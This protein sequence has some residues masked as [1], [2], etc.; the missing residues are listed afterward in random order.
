MIYL[1][2]FGYPT[3]GKGILLYQK[4]SVMLGSS[5]VAQEVENPALYKEVMDAVVAAKGNKDLLAKSFVIGQDQSGNAALLAIKVKQP[6]GTTK[7]IDISRLL[8]Q[9]EGDAAQ[10]HMSAEYFESQVDRVQAAL[11]KSGTVGEDFQFTE[12]QRISVFSRVYNGSPPSSLFSGLESGDPIKVLEF[13]TANRGGNGNNGHY[14]RSIEE[15]VK[16]LGDSVIPA[17]KG[18]ANGF[19]Y[20]DQDGNEVFIGSEKVAK[21]PNGQPGAGDE[22]ALVAYKVVENP[23]GT[24]SQVNIDLKISGSRGMNQASDFVDPNVALHNA[25]FDGNPT[26]I[27]KA[28]SL[29]PQNTTP[30]SVISALG[31]FSPEVGQIQDINIGSDLKPIWVKGYV[32]VDEN[33]NTIVIASGKGTDG[34]AGI[35]AY[36][37]AA[38]SADNPNPEP[39]L[40]DVVSKQ[41][42]IKQL[43]ISDSGE[44][45]GPKY[46]STSD[47]SSLVG[48]GGYVFTSEQY[49]LID[50]VQWVVGTNNTVSRYLE[51]GVIET[52]ILKD[53]GSLGQGILQDGN[54]E[55]V[56]MLAPSDKVGLTDAGWQINDG[57]GNRYTLQGEPI[58]ALEPNQIISSQISSETNLGLSVAQ[59]DQLSRYLANFGSDVQIGQLPN[60]EVLVANDAGEVLGV[61]KKEADGSVRF[62]DNDKNGTEINQDGKSQQVVSGLNEAELDRQQAHQVQAGFGAVQSALSLIQALENGNTFAASV[63]GVSMINQMFAAS[64]S[65][66]PELASF[67]ETLG[68]VGAGLG[69]ISSA[70]NLADALKSG[71]ALA[72]LQS[73]ATLGAQGINLYASMEGLKL[74][75][76]AGNSTGTL[77]TVAQDLGV[78]GAGVGLV[79][80][81]QSGNP[82]SMV[83]SSLSLL[84]ALG[85]I[86]PYGAVAAVIISLVSSMFGSDQPMLEGQAQA[87]WDAAGNTHVITTQDNEG[88]GATAT[89]WMNTLVSGLQ[90]Q[91]AGMVD[92]NGQPLYGLITP[93]LPSVGYQ[94]DPDGFNLANGAK[95]HLYLKWVDEN[96]QEQTRYYDGAGSRGDGT[97][98]T[99]VS[100]FMK[101]AMEAVVPAWEA[102]TV[103]Q[104]YLQDGVSATAKQG[105]RAG[106]PVEDAQHLTQSFTALSF[107]AVAVP[108]AAANAPV[109]VDIDGDGYLEKTDWISANQGMLAIDLNGDGKIGAGELLNLDPGSTLERNSLRW[110]DANRDGLLDARDP[111]FAALKVWIDANHD[112]LSQTATATSAGELQSMAAAGIVAINFASNPPVLV[113]ADGST[114]AL[115]VQQLTGDV[116]GVAYM[117][118][119]GGLLE[120]QEGGETILHAINTREFDGQAAHTH[121]GDADADGG[122]VLVGAGNADLKSTTSKTLPGNSQRTDTTLN[123]GDARLANGAAGAAISGQGAAQSAANTTASQVRSNPLAFVPNGATT[124]AQQVRQVTEEM[125]RNADNSLFGLSSVSTPL[126]AVGVAAAA[127][128]WPAVAAASDLTPVAQ[129]IGSVAPASTAAGSAMSST[130]LGALLAG[131]TA[132]GSS[133]GAAGELLVD[134]VSGPVTASTRTASVIATLLPNPVPVASAPETLVM[135]PGAGATGAEG[136]VAAGGNSNDSTGA[137][138]QTVGTTAASTAASALSAPAAPADVVLDYP[139]VV[140]EHVEGIEDIVLR[141]PESLL[142]ANDSTINFPAF[143]DRQM[144][145][146]SSVFSATH[147]QVALRTNEEGK[148]E[149]VFLPEAN[150]HGLASFNYTVTDQYG[151][152]SVG[153]TTVSIAAVNDAPVVRDDR[154]AGDE[155]TVLMF[156]AADLLANDSDVDSAVD[157]DVLRI[158]R[159]GQA[160]HGQV[161]LDPDGIIRFI[162]DLNYNGPAQFTYWVGDRDVSQLV[163][164]GGEGYEIPGTMHL[165]VIPVNDLPVVTG[166]QVDSDEDIVLDFAQSFL[167]ANDTDVDIATNGQVL[168]ITAVSNAQHGVVELLQD[169][170]VRFTPELNYFGPAAF[171][172]TVDDGNGGRVV[173]TTVVNLAPVNDAP[174]VVGETI[175]FD[176]DIVQTID[177]ALLLANDSD[178][179]NAHSELSIIAVDNAT[180][181]VVSLNPDG[182]IRFVP[183]AD[184]F[185]AASF[186]YTV[187]DGV[188]GFTVGTASLQ[189]NPVNDAPRLQGETATTDE[190]QVL[191][192]SVDGLLSNDHDVDNDHAELRLT[193]VG[194]ASHGTVR[195]ENG[196]IIFTPD[197][198]YFGAASFT[199]VVDDGVGGQSEA[200]VDLQFNSVNDVPVVND[201][202]LTGKR[203]VTYTLT[204]A[205]LL[206]N[207]TDVEDPNALSIVAVRNASHGSVVLNPNG[208]ITFVPESG[209]AGTGSFEYVVRDPDG[210]EVVGTTQIDFSRI[211]VNPVAVD[212]SFIGFEDTAFVIAANQLL[213]NDTDPDPGSLSRLSVSAVGN[214]SHGTVSL[215]GDGSVR[216]MPAQDFYGTASFQY[217]VSDGEGGQTWATAYLNV[218]A[219]NDA[220]VIEDIWYGRPIYGYRWSEV[221]QITEGG[222]ATHGGW[223]LV[224]VTDEATAI[225]LASNPYDVVTGVDGATRA[226]DLVDGNGNPMGLS[227]YRSG[228]LR[229]VAIDYTDAMDMVGENG[230]NSLDDNSRQNGKVIA[231]DVDGSTADLSFSIGSGPQHGHAWANQYTATNSPSGIDHTQAGNYAVYDK[232]AWQYYSHRGDPYSGSD[233]FSVRVTDAQGASV[234]AMISTAHVGSSAGGGGKCPIVVDLDGDGIELVKPQ[235][236]HMFADLNGQ[237]WRERIGW[238]STDDG[239]LAFDAN[240]DGHITD[241][242]EISF[243]S[244]K[245]GA[246]TDLEGLA[247][248][249]SDGDGKLTSHDA[250]WSSFGILRD[251]NKNGVQDAGEFISLDQMGITSIGLQRHGT[252]EV[253]NGNVVFGTSDVAFA[254]GHTTQ[255]GDVMFGGEITAFPD[256]AKAVLAAAHPPAASESAV[257]PAAADP[258]VTAVSGTVPAAAPPAQAVQTSEATQPSVASVTPAASEPVGHTESALAAMDDLAAIRQMALLFNQVVA[259]SP[260]LAEEPLSFV[261]AS[262]HSISLATV[263]TG[264]SIEGAVHDPAA[265]AAENALST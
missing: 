28:L 26:E 130:D 111:A 205:A 13:F 143:P 46:A 159:V 14:S 218:Q 44:W 31:E 85:Y 242:K 3:I 132:T 200:R 156:R 252:P 189:I 219:V 114:V 16:Y 29:Q 164:A 91:L 73:S 75:D 50:N 198:N 264:V 215:Q 123:A 66:P 17:V 108:G 116:K 106:M 109:Y 60:G 155:D 196:E 187:S 216:F 147:G 262:D 127:T 38:V 97:G 82:V 171:S 186:T 202:L 96:G 144:L 191:H 121:G 184:H 172:Y 243:V 118:T 51:G 253:N 226:N 136:S 222:W 168:R 24:L 78:V 203:N 153:T 112:G 256:A 165:T 42:A 154:A 72:I 229:P 167:L 241:S 135:F 180:H 35:V 89:G 54:G 227:Y 23:D 211:N 102:E 88:G 220:P 117:M 192:F 56:G 57:H 53:D 246:R 138:V 240:L 141:L 134:H 237:G 81:I 179:D 2:K 223:R 76:A 77:G 260:V 169:G 21:V 146:I 10:K 70:I 64:G 152:S 161:F 174:D 247:A 137:G 69:A 7:E 158:T 250:L 162:P 11:I 100:D 32:Y 193:S 6:D 30:A 212:D 98:E 119:V 4:G 177:Q 39:H 255:A 148:T 129:S 249:D 204:Q 58:G 150:Y 190:D 62:I 194:N 126:V 25:V 207:D 49:A 52:R 233:P 15:A 206:A 263:E 133:T 48:E 259:S 34:K 18:G 254:D 103:R 175:S 176:E 149:I 79:M 257:V 183:D 188:G 41:S 80:A 8:S 160:Q 43:K 92:A 99:L 55:L 214:A 213:V 90:S 234:D 94:Y 87:V 230:Y 22:R 140:G 1:D 208:T 235:D 217:Q 181:G 238:A 115:N 107:P 113:K 74:F 209:Y 40:L 105:E 12:D 67:A 236:S 224:S 93:R 104:H 197:L 5:Y 163:S 68:K 125:I 239:I 20:Y 120:S 142:L 170:T 86:G 84:S 131:A 19:L 258:P 61:V 128:Q 185:G 248:F 65:V 151:L 122:Q 101:H 221:I 33:D 124:A 63:A 178:V 225:A 173:G 36:E 195:L 166:E 201:E 182:S 261:P 9:S 210:A 245:E 59:L 47:P 231:Y 83:S 228:Q 244:Y 232:G 145:R 27:L 95:G 199:Y 157:G 37:I 45:E 265:R 110:L 139:T 251:L 71:D